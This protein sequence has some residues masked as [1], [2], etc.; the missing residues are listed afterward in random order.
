MMQEN[1]LSQNTAL[2]SEEALALISD[3]WTIRI[4][5]AL[6]QG[7]SRYGAIKRAIPDV[8]KKMLT[9]RLRA[10]ERDG[11]TERFDFSKAVPHVEYTLTPLGKSLAQ[12]VATLCKWFDEHLEEITEAR[13]NYDAT[14]R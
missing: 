14:G 6:L 1:S 5:H 11:L 9:Q 4:M 2:G 7:N 10:M 8:T 3:K 13:K 12:H